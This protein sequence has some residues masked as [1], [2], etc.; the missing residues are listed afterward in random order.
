MISINF[1]LN[2]KILDVSNSKFVA[3]GTEKWE[4]GKPLKNM[5]ARLASSVDYL[6]P[7]GK[8]RTPVTV[9]IWAFA[10]VA[11]AEGHKFLRT[12]I[13]FLSESSTHARIA[14][15]PTDVGSSSFK[16]MLKAAFADNDIAKAKKVLEEYS[17][18]RTNE[19]KLSGELG[20]ISATFMRLAGVPVGGKGLVV[21]GRIIGPLDDD[22]TFEV[23]D[24]A[25]VEKFS[26]DSCAKYFGNA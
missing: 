3:F 24:W 20:E 7:S 15:I 26:Y 6:T 13:D 12:A 19:E 10:N 22:D 2:D 14:F 16:D 21:N 4:P 17:D 18:E 9:T 11:T 25:L 1:R 8:R 23:G 5:Y